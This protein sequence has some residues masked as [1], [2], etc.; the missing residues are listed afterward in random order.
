MFNYGYNDWLDSSRGGFGKKLCEVGKSGA[1]AQGFLTGG[2]TIP[3]SV[4]L[5]C[6]VLVPL[7]FLS[8]FFHNCT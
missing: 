8:V 6:F 2:S 5:L 1:N 4:N 7:P 3:P